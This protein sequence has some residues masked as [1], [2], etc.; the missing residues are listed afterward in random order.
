MRK[1]QVQPPEE[2]QMYYKPQKYPTK[3]FQNGVTYRLI[4]QSN[5]VDGNS[6]V[7]YITIPKYLSLL[8]PNS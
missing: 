2:F 8:N 7:M 3:D 4:A 6:G 5:T 1:V